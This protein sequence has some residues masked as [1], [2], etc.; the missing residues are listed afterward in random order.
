MQKPGI[1]CNKSIFF[2]TDLKNMVLKVDVWRLESEKTGKNVE[3]ICKS[4]Y[5]GNI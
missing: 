5:S 2:Y 4:V 3:F 1:K